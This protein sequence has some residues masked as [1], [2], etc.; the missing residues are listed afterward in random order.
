MHFSLTYGFYVLLINDYIFSSINFFRFA[1]CNQ[2]NQ[3]LVVVFLAQNVAHGKAIRAVY[4]Y[5]LFNFVH[6][7]EWRAVF[8]AG[9]CDGKGFVVGVR[10]RQ[11]FQLVADYKF[12]ALFHH[13]VAVVAHFPDYCDKL[14][15]L[16]SLA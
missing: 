6:Y 10:H 1:Y 8:V 12:V 16:D 4:A 9:I 7:F 14:V 15:L 2:Q 13:Y 11:R 3:L 5:N